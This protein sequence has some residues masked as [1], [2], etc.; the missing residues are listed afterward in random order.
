MAKLRISRVFACDYGAGYSTR[1]VA[2][3]NPSRVTA[4]GGGVCSGVGDAMVCDGHYVCLWV[5]TSLSVVCSLLTDYNVHEPARGG[6]HSTA[7][8]TS[9][10]RSPPHV[11]E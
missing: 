6:R 4:T 1:A 3:N 2:T 7:L 10:L 5:T 9:G 11:A 8:G